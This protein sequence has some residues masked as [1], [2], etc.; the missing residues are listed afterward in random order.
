MRPLEYLLI[1]RNHFSTNQMVETTR[2]EL[3]EIL[4]C[5]DRNV[6]FILKKLEDKKY[7][8][9]VSGRGRGVHSKIAFHLPFHEIAERYVN[10]LVQNEA[11]SDILSFLENTQLEDENR[12]IIFEKLQEALQP[13][14]EV[15]N[16]G[17]IKST[18]SIL[19]PQTVQTLNPSE[20]FLY[21]EA[22]LVKQIY[23][24]LV[25]YN[26]GTHQV[27]PSLA[28]AWSE[29]NNGQEWTFYLRKAVHFHN[30]DLLT[31]KDVKFT[32]TKMK[33]LGQETFF[34][35]LLNDLREI[36]IINDY[37]VTFH[38]NK[39]NWVFPYLLCSYHCSILSKS[40]DSM[41]TNG[42]GPFM[43]TDK[44]EHHIRLQAFDGYF[45]E[46]AIIDE[47]D[48]WMTKKFNNVELNKIQVPEAVTAN[49]RVKNFEF[50]GSRFLVFNG[51]KGGIH[52]N[53][54]FR[55]ALVSLYEPKKIV[56]DLKGNRTL[57]AYSF[58][59]ENSRIHAE[60]NNSI[61]KA[62]DFLE[63]SG[64]RGE[65]I[66]LYYFD[67]NEGYDSALWLQE[68]ARKIGISLSVHP[69][70][71]HNPKGRELLTQA[72]IVLL[73]VILQEEIG[74]SLYCLYKSENGFLRQFFSKDLKRIIDD[75]LESFV[76]ERELSKRNNLLQT[77][78][79]YLI[80]S[81]S[82]H[83]LYHSITRVEFNTFLKD[84]SLA[85]LNLPD[86]DKIW[87]DSEQDKLE[88][89]NPKA[90]PPN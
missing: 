15:A 64:Y 37:T 25:E 29:H 14:I 46:R 33:K 36:E 49:H 41:G 28:Y 50:T 87:I 52:H 45:K 3:A 18:V 54:Y 22:H 8:T 61:N 74:F 43:L 57:P 85:T 77:I 51:S 6:N 56:N 67:I 47:V 62:K 58:L 1:L 65:P 44:T 20:V 69:I 9:W 90:I 38:L 60:R 82:L 32:F 78:E 68:E 23:N 80:E 24:T 75:I 7:V 40:T 66:T 17:E 30:G 39:T 71:D 13:K 27:E 88:L 81:H 16:S 31:A 70:P 63:L 5:T 21:T 34:H 72:D 84:F 26:E 73:S 35:S 79:T 83:F 86:F 48:I 12:T 59:P 2:H 55:K 76:N 11:I 89:C 42:T 10:K 4:F 53:P 19:L